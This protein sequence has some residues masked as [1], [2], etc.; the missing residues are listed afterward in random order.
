[1]YNTCL[2][3]LRTISHCWFS[4]WCLQIVRARLGRSQETG[5]Q[6]RS[7]TWLAGTKLLDPTLLSPKEQNITK[8]PGLG[9]RAVSQPSYSKIGWRYLF[10]YLPKCLSLSLILYSRM[11]I[12]FPNLSQCCFIFYSVFKQY[13][14][15]NLVEESTKLKIFKKRSLCWRN[16]IFIHKKKNDL[17]KNGVEDGSWVVTAFPQTW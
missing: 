14:L 15:Y 10:I 8:K 3:K 4:F 5:T 12:L 9:A 2:W 16:E 7:P 1:M 13:C 6:F 11:R 17:I